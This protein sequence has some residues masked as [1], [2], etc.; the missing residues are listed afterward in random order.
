MF[1]CKN[2][3]SSFYRAYVYKAFLLSYICCSSPLLILKRIVY[4]F[5]SYSKEINV[6]MFIYLF[7]VL[8]FIPYAVQTPISMFFKVN[9]PFKFCLTPK[10]LDS[11]LILKNNLNLFWNSEKSCRIMSTSLLKL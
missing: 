7:I 4:N 2:I 3:S 6:N 9:T 11:F 8:F 10:T 1:L 5:L